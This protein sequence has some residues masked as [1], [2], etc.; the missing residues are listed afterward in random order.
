MPALTLVG[1][2]FDI[3]PSMGAVPD[4]SGEGGPTMTWQTSL[5]LSGVGFTILPSTSAATVTLTVPDPVLAPRTVRAVV[6]VL[7]L[8]SQMVLD[9]GDGEQT[10][11]DT[12]ETHPYLEGGLKAVTFTAYIEALDLDVQAVA[13]ITLQ[14]AGVPPAETPN[15]TPTLLAD[16]TLLPRETRDD[17]LNITLGRHGYE[18]SFAMHFPVDRNT[19][20]RRGLA[21]V[22]P[23]ND[24]VTLITFVP[25]RDVVIRS[26]NVD[27]DGDGQ[28]YLRVAGF[29]EASCIVNRQRGSGKLLS[30]D[31]YIPVPRGVEITVVVRNIGINNATF[32]A[33]VFAEQGPVGVL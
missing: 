5:Y 19:I 3:R 32:R 30:S 33:I 8:A 1:V 10:N 20:R 16:Y 7:P 21:T 31:A 25:D 13:S 24:E 29:T 22:I 27:T 2:G 9:W 18:H 11:N 15:A 14:E 23:S 4:T 6:S 28:F 26:A 17:V 12:D